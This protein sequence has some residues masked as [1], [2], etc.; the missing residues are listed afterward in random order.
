MCFLDKYQI[1]KIDLLHNSDLIAQSCWIWNNLVAAKR[2]ELWR[3]QPRLSAG[4]LGITLADWLTTYLCCIE[5]RLEHQ[6][7]AES[8]AVWWWVLLQWHHT[9]TLYYYLLSS[10]QQ[11]NYHSPHSTAIM[12]NSRSSLQLQP[13]DITAI[14]EETG[15]NQNQIER[16]YSR[17]V[18]LP[19]YCL[20][21]VLYSRA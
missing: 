8:Q 5:N 12:G 15:F 17:W 3:R 10:I 9:C 4:L 16:L 13:E 19:A 2:S 6:P 1:T 11:I 18:L 21:W 20:G 7:R 14:Q